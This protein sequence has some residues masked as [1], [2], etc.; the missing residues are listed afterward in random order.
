ML[1]KQAGEG[2]G[3]KLPNL[4][5]KERLLRR[6]IADMITIIMMIMIP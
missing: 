4:P 2:G 6:K 3:S 5:C 1:A